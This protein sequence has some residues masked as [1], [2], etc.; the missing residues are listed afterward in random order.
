MSTTL[1]NW[2]LSSRRTR[3]SWKAASCAATQELPYTLWNPKVHYHVH[4]SPILS[5][6]N[7]VQPHHPISLRSILI[8]SAHLHLGLLVIS[9]FLVFPPISYMHSLIP[10]LCYMPWPF[11]A[12]W[13][14]HSNYNLRRVQVMKLLIMQFSSTLVTS[15]LL[16][17]NILLS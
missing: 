16:D 15:S 10:H 14:D 4:M 3:P 17:S 1:A 8:L 12:P 6:N 9:F 2:I 13:L 11:H 5:Q 7:P